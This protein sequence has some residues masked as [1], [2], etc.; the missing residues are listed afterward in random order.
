MLP[1]RPIELGE[2]FGQIWPFIWLFDTVRYLVAATLMSIVLWAFWDAGLGRRKIQSRCPIPRDVCREVMTSLRTAAI[3]SLIGFG[4]SVAVSRGW[5]VLYHDFRQRGV[6]YL[7]ATLALMIVVHDAYFYWTHRLM[8][9][10]RLFR[11]F[12]LTHHK[13]HVP[14]PW[15]AYAFAAPEA[16]V[17]GAFMP[18][19]V[20]LLPMHE[21][22]LFIFMTFQ[23]VRNVMG[24]A[25]VEVHPAAMTRS[26]LL[27]WNNTT[28]HHDLHHQT[29]HYNFGL[30]FR[31]WDRLM[32]TEHPDY[33]QRF[34]AVTDSAR[35]GAMR[36]ASRIALCGL[37]GAA[38]ALAGPPAGAFDPKGA[39]LGE[40]GTQGMNAKVNMAQCPGRTD[41][42]CGTITWL[43][44]P[45]DQSGRPRT[46]SQNPV[47]GMRDR[48]LIGMQILSG[49][50]RKSSGEL[51]GGTIYNPEDGRTYDATMR[52]QGSDT[53]VVEGCVLFVCRKQVWRKASAICGARPPADEAR[54]TGIAQ[55]ADRL[56]GPRARARPVGRCSP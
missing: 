21:L 50:R 8:H 34:E 3:F 35:D 28:T 52:L 48:P 43:W 49:F 18:L 29:G 33:L 47:A 27:G 19:F 10:P 14:T 55:S 11:W 30:Y 16:L 37:A 44:E 7:F 46:D 24:H 39:F 32:G 42:I 15:A 4:L 56:D 23:I 17:Q 12:H 2:A 1:A 26:R 22:A 31:W 40:W 51:G 9:H 13:S 36:L 25:G 41:L 53:L 20:A 5:I 45:V 6:G 54:G 38:I